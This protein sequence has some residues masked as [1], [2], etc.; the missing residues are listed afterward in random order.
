[1]KGYDGGIFT[2]NDKAKW[3]EMPEDQRWVNRRLRETNTP[4]NTLPREF[5]PNGTYS[6]TWRETA[7]EFALLHYNWLVGNTK[8]TK[9]KKNGHWLIPYS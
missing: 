7:P 2:M 1:M 5:Y 4:Y 6:D 9:M 8:I 3:Q